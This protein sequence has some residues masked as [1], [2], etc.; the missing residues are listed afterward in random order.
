[1]YTEKGKILVMVSG[2]EVDPEAQRRARESYWQT[3]GSEAVL[4]FLRSI[5]KRFTEAFL[6][7][8]RSIDERF[9]EAVLEF[10]R[11]IKVGMLKSGVVRREGDL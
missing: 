9:T 8:L 2:E 11:P 4:D 5:D 10:L 3:K 1:M 6:E 7:F